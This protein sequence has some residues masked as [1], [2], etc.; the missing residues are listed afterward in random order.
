VSPFTAR[1][2]AVISLV[3]RLL[4]AQAA[5]SAAIALSYSR[6]NTGWLVFTVIAAI[7]ACGLARL[8]RSASQTAWLVALGFEGVYVAIGLL[9]FGY[10]AY[11]GGTLL[12][13]ITVGTLLRPSV[14]RVFAPHPAEQGAREASVTPSLPF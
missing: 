9:R 13:I 10:S 12:G 4:L 6:R 5:V 2:H 14:A 7:A 1:R 11:L 8:V 3:S